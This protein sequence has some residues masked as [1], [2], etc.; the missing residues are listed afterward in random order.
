MTRV[1]QFRGDPKVIQGARSGSEHLGAPWY[2]FVDL[3]AGGVAVGDNKGRDVVLLKSRRD[4]HQ[5]RSVRR[6]GEPRIGRHRLI[7]HGLVSFMSAD[8]S[9][10]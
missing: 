1:V 2:E 10:P 5:P 7:V 9:V 4:F 8:R 3:G 6:V